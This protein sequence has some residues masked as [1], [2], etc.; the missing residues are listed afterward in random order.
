MNAFTEE[1]LYTVF[2]LHLW[3]LCQNKFQSSGLDCLLATLQVLWNHLGWRR[4]WTTGKRVPL[5][6]KSNLHMHEYELKGKEG[7]VLPCTKGV[8]QEKTA[9]K[10]GCSSH[11]LDFESCTIRGRLCQKPGLMGGGVHLQQSKHTGKFYSGPSQLAP[12]TQS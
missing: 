11:C 8:A 5:V 2:L 6:R 12:P 7:S 1:D 3:G 4:K 10:Q 9:Q